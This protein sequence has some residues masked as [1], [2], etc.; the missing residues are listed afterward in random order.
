MRDLRRNGYSGSDAEDL[1]P[2]S[3]AEVHQ[4]KISREHYHRDRDDSV[5]G[6]EGT[7]NGILSEETCR[8][9]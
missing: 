2:K 9:T 8:N 5:I 7:K 3:V 6:I 4:R 1:D